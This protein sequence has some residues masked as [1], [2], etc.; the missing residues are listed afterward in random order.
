MNEVKNESKQVSVAKPEPV[1][2]IYLSIKQASEST[3]LS[4]RTINYL[5]SEGRIRAFKVG[6]RTLLRV[7]ELERLGK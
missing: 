6:R 2:R 5:I 1:K 7:S 3:S 4:P